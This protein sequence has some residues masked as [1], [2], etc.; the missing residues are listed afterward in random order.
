MI[1]PDGI[2]FLL[3]ALTSV[4]YS[5]AVRRL[6]RLRRALTEGK[7]ANLSSIWTFA[8]TMLL[9]PL[10]IAAVVAVTY[11]AGW[12][13]RRL[14]NG[15][16]PFRYLYSCAASGTA[17]LAAAAVLHRFDVGVVATALAL[18]TFSA[19][20]IGLI[21]AA[22]VIARQFHVLKMFANVKA[23]AV[24]LATQL[25]GVALAGLMSWHVALGVLVV[26]ALLLV[27]CWSLRETVKDEDA[28]D[29]VAGL[30]SETAWRVQAQQ[31]LHDARGHVALMIIDPDKPGL[32]Y[33]IL[34]A[35]R[36][37]L[38]PSD[39]L[40]RYGTRQIVLLIPVGR[41]AAGQFMSTGFRA[42]LA[43]A[44]VPAALGCATTADA[45]LE[46]LLIEAM[47][48]LMGRRAAAGVHRRW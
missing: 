48:D 6:E 12:P 24:E 1:G 10:L 47:S 33:A 5:V 35:I 28:Y 22:L 8:A 11:A 27:H 37:G 20:D 13:S 25:L 43:A 29:E 38:S 44:A 31:K 7:M 16:R 17:C 4:T 40:G 19:L 3:L 2:Y 21:A 18:L 9:P 14:V 26:P 34:E 46:G 30:W 23:H 32:E 42:D 36:S 39:L 41:P 45:E 15:G